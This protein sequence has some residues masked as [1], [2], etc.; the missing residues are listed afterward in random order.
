MKKTFSKQWSNSKKPRKQKKFLKNAPLHI[1]KKFVRANLSKELQKKSNKR[2]FGLRRDDK[3]KIV[4]GQFKGKSGKV[5]SVLVKKSKVI[6]TGIE[7]IKKE[8]S[9]TKYP[10]HISNIVIETLALDDKKRDNKFKSAESKKIPKKG[11][12]Q[13]DKKS[14]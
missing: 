5:E 7:A 8:G 10:V 12:N 14:S 9:K 6:I 11:K 1:K 4:R 2:S 3:V 13:N